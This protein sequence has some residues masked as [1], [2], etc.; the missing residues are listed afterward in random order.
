MAR[1]RSEQLPG[2][3]REVRDVAECRVAELLAV[4]LALVGLLTVRASISTSLPDKEL[5]DSILPI[6]HPVEGSSS[7]HSLQ[8]AKNPSYCSSKPCSPTCLALPFPLLPPLVISPKTDPKI[9]SAE[10]P[11]W[12]PKDLRRKAKIVRSVTNLP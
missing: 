11:D 10:A 3:S 2:M 5:V 4:S 7:P 6:S 12:Y 1:K 8:P 9:S